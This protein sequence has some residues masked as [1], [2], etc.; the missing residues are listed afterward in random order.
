MD[1]L[2]KTNNEE[3]EDKIDETENMSNPEAKQE[4]IV[5]EVAPPE[6][7]PA[8]VTERGVSFLKKYKKIIAAVAAVILVVI[9]ICAASKPK[10]ISISASYDGDTTDG[11]AL[12][13]KNK[14]ITVTGINEK[15]KEVNVSGWEID[16]PTVL[17]ADGSETVEIIYKD[18]KTELTV[19][20]TSSEAL[21]ISASYSDSLKEG[22]TIT[23]DNV[24]VVATLKNGEE[25]DVTKDSKMSPETI[26]LEKDGTYDL[27]FEYTDPISGSVLSSELSLECSTMSIESISAKYTGDTE[28]G[29]LIDKNNSGITVTAVLK[30]GTKKELQ[31]W[32]IEK[33]VELK[34]DTTSSVKITFEEFSCDLK[35]I[36]STMSESK[37][38]EMCKSIS[39]DALLRNPGKN[40]GKYIK[41]TG[42]VF[43]VVSEASSPLYYSAYF[44]RSDGNLYMIKL[45]NYGSESRILEDDT[46]TVWGTVDEIYTYETVRGN[47]NTI[48]QIMAKYFK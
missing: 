12:S 47:S 14:G 17:K 24:S 39:Y 45:D 19:E 15:G 46:I 33:P 32:E 3:I 48:P 18:L 1:E 43:Q 36:C 25:S 44:I 27:K 37:Y 26:T 38:K 41:V 6:K 31:D 40:K 10:I 22:V 9:I 29:T 7:T 16:K 23:K 5:D 28:A 8:D 21:K 4:N 42:T 2:N 11:V 35:I 30:N 20:C 34:A 13:E